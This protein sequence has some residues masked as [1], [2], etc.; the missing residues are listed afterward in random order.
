MSSFIGIQR[1]KENSKE[2]I[3]II[4]KT[5]LKIIENVLKSPDS[6]EARRIYLDSEDVLVNLMPFS[7]GLESL[8]EIGFE[9]VIKILLFF[10]LNFL[11]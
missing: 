3:L 6:V 1:I 8:F 5:L 11:I 7:G 9:E 4:C 2:N 10:Q